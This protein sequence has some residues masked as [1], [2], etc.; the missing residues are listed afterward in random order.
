M[1]EHESLTFRK[2]LERGAFLRLLV[3]NKADKSTGVLFGVSTH[4][5][6][7]AIRHALRQYST[8]CLNARTLTQL[9]LQV[10]IK[11]IRQ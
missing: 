2:P 9:G 4:R 3:N 11:T 7:T 5:Y 10:P 1:Q 8:L 6:K